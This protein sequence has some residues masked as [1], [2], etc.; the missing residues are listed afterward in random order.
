MYDD[1]GGPRGEGD[2]MERIT[3]NMTDHDGDPFPC[4]RKMNEK[5]RRV[6]DGEFQR[7]KRKT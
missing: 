5:G 3:T 1:V 6:K 7:K 2:T 4:G